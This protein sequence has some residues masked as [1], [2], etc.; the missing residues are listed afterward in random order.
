MSAI[1]ILPASA[2][3]LAA[4]DRWHAFMRGA[5]PDVASAPLGETPLHRLARNGGPAALVARLLDASLREKRSSCLTR[6]EARSLICRISLPASR[7]MAPSGSCITG[8]T[9]GIVTAR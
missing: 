7:A 4:I 9:S 1:S 3:L 5:D 8:T 6:S 2:D